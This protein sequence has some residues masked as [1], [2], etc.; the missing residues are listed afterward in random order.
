MGAFAR[1]ITTEGP[2]N[3]IKFRN[4]L[5]DACRNAE[6]YAPH[7]WQLDVVEALYLGIDTIVIAGT[8]AG[9]TLPFVLSHLVIKD[10]TSI[11]ISPLN[12]LEENQVSAQWT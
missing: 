2:Y 6:G 7:E 3:Y 5:I 4:D 9:K 1:P 10:K 11:I 8:G 12:A